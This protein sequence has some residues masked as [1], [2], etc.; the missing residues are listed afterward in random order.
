MTIRRARNFAIGGIK[1]SEKIRPK[2]ISIC[3][4]RRI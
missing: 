2:K 4:K 3:K 1:G